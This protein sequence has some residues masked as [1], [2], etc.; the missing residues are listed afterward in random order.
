MWLL[1][2]IRAEL[3]AIHILLKDEGNGEETDQ[4]S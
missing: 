2:D 3:M 4:N 1:A